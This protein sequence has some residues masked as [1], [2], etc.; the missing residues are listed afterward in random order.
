MTLEMNLIVLQY[1]NQ[2]IN[3]LI[4]DVRLHISGDSE[5]LEHFDQQVFDIKL[6]N[7]LDV[8]EISTSAQSR[9]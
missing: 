4:K 5:L 2:L 3:N 1:Q 6:D 7:L 8:F 9:S